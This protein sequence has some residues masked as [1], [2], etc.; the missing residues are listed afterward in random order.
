MELIAFQASPSLPKE[1][2]P[3]WI[4]WLLLCFVVLL[5]FFIFLRDKALRMRLSSFLAGARRRSILIRLR[6][7]VKKENQKKGV[8]LQKLGA[9]AWDED[10]CVN[11]SRHVCAELEALFER[12]STFQAEWKKSFAEVERL[13]KKLEESARAQRHT[14]DLDGERFG[15]QGILRPAS[16]GE[17]DCQQERADSPASVNGM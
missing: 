6:F 1:G 7:Q 4:F 9:K 11:G 3:Y 8:L 14:T 17:P 16:A 13:H 15:W 2:L 10:I 5:L 12:K